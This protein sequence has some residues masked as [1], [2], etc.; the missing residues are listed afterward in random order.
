MHYLNI[1]MRPITISNTNGNWYKFW[2][3]IAIA[4]LTK[5]RNA[6]IKQYQKLLTMDNIQL[7]FN[8]EAI[9]AIAQEGYRRKTGAR[10]LRGIVEELM[11]EVMYEMP[12]R[13]DIQRCI[14]TK[15]MVEKRSTAELLV[16]PTTLVDQESA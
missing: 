11:L 2:M 5:P 9:S 12:S 13:D 10:A 7:E 8:K 4:I 16:Y 6:I 1:P 3:S 15:E 14:I